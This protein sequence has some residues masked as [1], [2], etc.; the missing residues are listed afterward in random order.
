VP[1]R[2]VRPLEL[3]VSTETGSGAILVAAAIAALV[4]ANAAP[5][6]YH[7]LWS[8][9]AVAGVGTLE[10]HLDLRTVV[11][12]LLMALFFY[13]VALE[14]KREF[15][16]GA[17]RDRSYAALPIAA[18][19]G[20]MVGAALAYLAVNL[21]GD[22]N[23][24]GWA[25]PIA[26]DIAF[27]LAALGLV[28]RR[29]PAELRTFLLTLAVVDDLATI[30]VIAVFYSHGLSLA[31][32]GG[33]A[34]ALAFTFGMQRIGVRSITPYVVAAA[35]TWI[36][37]HESGVHA[38]IAG[39]ALGF[40]TPSRPFYPRRSTGETIAEQLGNVVAE[41]DEEVSAAAMSEVSRLSRETVS[42][43]ARMEHALH[44]WSAYLVLPLFALGNAGVEVTVAGIGDALTAP[45]GLGILLGLVIGAPIGGILMPLAL[46]R[47]TGATLPGGLDWPAIAAM[48]PLKGIGFTVAIFISILAFDDQTLQAQAT[49]A[50]LIASLLAGLI[51]VGALS[52][53]HRLVDRRGA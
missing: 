2:I 9:G 19:F 14:V 21:I 38:T 33:G 39:V 7:D 23:L 24:N 41:R 3:F 47:L 13:V 18:A 15:I 30:A 40:L 43:L 4:W 27:A 35:A 36:A 37:V 26:T 48:A 28:G 31:W 53:R 12:D 46:A 32:L 29:A 5:D 25:I 44:P 49:L 34:L 45:V 17:L 42:P 50:I 8:T 52:V 11:N 16:F 22:G 10:L 6:S 1:R 51:G 20:T